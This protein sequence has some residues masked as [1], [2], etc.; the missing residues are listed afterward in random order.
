MCSQPMVQAAQLARVRVCVARI[1]SAETC[2][3]AS[4]VPVW[5]LRVGNA[6]K[7][8]NVR[9]LAAVPSSRYL[10]VAG[11]KERCDSCLLR[12]VSSRGCAQAA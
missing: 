3:A 10:A 7:R 8:L 12:S 11:P 5:K 1:R 4:K 2:A 9:R 6:P